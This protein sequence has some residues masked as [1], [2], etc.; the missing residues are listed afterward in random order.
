[1][2]PADLK[3]NFEVAVFVIGGVV[4]PVV[5]SLVL[6]E[7][8]KNARA[9]VGICVGVILIILF[10]AFFLTYLRRM[11]AREASSLFSSALDK[12]I[13]YP[14]KGHLRKAGIRNVA[15]RT[16]TLHDLLNEVVKAVPDERRKDALYLAG[17][18]VGM[19]WGK[20]LEK[21]SYDLMG[22]AGD[23]DT[24]LDLWMEYDKSGGLGVFDF[25]I[26]H[27]GHGEIC[28]TNS[29]LSDEPACAP[30]NYCFAGYVAGTLEYILGIQVNVELDNPSTSCQAKTHFSVSPISDLGVGGAH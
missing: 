13:V 12:Y 21:L 23:V 6:P 3:R 8:P 9:P 10:G 4:V 15:L 5:T 24:K 11:F 26:T 17:Y 27:E 16:S 25:S 28:L 20:D 29:V 14:L 22:D 7:L 19:S 2:P 18:T 30:L 1:L